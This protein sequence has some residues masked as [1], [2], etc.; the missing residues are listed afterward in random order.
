ML[1]WISEIEVEASEQ[2]GRAWGMRSGI[3]GGVAREG[4]S[5]YP[6]LYIWHGAVTQGQGSTISS[7]GLVMPSGPQLSTW[8]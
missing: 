8:V 5:D 3:R 4:E 6:D 1:V 2:L 7:R